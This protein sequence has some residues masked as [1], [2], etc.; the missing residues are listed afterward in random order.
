MRSELNNQNT[1]IR[2]LTIGG[3][4]SSSYSYIESYW[5]LPFTDILQDYYT[6]LNR[7]LDKACIITA[8]LWLSE[9]DIAQLDFLKL[10]YIEQ[11]GSYFLL[12]KV[13]NYI[14]GKPTTCE[15]VKVLFGETQQ[16]TREINITSFTSERNNTTNRY[17]V[18]LS[19]TTGYNPATLNLQWREIDTDEW[20][21][22]PAG[23][24]IQ[25]TTP[26]S[27][28]LSVPE[29]QGLICEFR[30]MDTFYDIS[31]NLRT[32]GFPLIALP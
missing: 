22:L 3:S 6:N 4:Q 8:E 10:Y 7:I 30:I 20:N 19:Y 5:K 16:I 14:P 29:F 2:D 1:S 13:N 23:Q 32:I 15:L 9:G 17:N 25:Y 12:N 26:F 11:L 28:Y 24:I 27:F 31:S 21:T 18:G